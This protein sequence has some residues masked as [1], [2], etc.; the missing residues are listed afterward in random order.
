MPEG[1]AEHWDLSDPAKFEW[2]KKE[3]HEFFRK[4]REEIKELTE[5]RPSGG[6]E[7]TSGREDLNLRPPAPKAGALPGCATPRKTAL[8]LT[9]TF[10]F[11]RSK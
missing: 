11:T 1:R 7:N 9:Q 6:L 8:I 10:E 3:K 5:S 4:T 2:S